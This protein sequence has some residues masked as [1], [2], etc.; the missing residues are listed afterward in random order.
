MT[1]LYN[2]IIAMDNLGRGWSLERI[3]PTT[4]LADICHDGPE[5]SSEECQR[6]F[7]RSRHPHLYR[8]RIGKGR[9]EY[10]E[11]KTDAISAAMRHFAMRV[12]EESDDDA[13]K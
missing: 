8:C 13:P 1:A 7:G 5:H 11:C 2:A 10:G 12:E 4:Y 6:K 9:Y 3:A